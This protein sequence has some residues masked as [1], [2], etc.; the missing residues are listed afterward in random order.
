MQV[1]QEGQGQGG[2]QADE[3]S[4]S[5]KVS[6]CQYECFSMSYDILDICR[7]TFAL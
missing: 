1:E 2:E 3:N 4:P 7:N 6:S 5:N